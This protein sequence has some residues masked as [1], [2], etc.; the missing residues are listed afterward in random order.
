MILAC[1]S[2]RDAAQIQSQQH[3][4]AARGKEK[5]Y[6]CAPAVKWRLIMLIATLEI[7]Q[8]W[9]IMVKLMLMLTGVDIVILEVVETTDHWMKEMM[10]KMIKNTSTSQKDYDWLC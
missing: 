7:S 1:R 6:I 5:C 4:T 3:S 9:S 8:E 2:L 10:L